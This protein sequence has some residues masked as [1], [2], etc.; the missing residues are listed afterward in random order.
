MKWENK[1]TPNK[2]GRYLVTAISNITK[3]SYVTI[4][5][6]NDRSNGQ[7]S[8]F[9]VMG[10]AFVDKITA[11]QEMPTPYFENAAAHISDL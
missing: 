6:L 11:W 3:E 10:G 2:P 4:A 7:L 1:G 8:W 5:E 9:Y